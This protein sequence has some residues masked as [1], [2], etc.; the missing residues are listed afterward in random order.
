MIVAKTNSKLG[1]VI[2]VLLLILAVKFVVGLVLGLI[3]TLLTIAFLAGLV[4]LV[5]W[6]YQQRRSSESSN[7][8]A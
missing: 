5:F 8:H 2:A 4:A 3:K 6:F 7:D 1:G